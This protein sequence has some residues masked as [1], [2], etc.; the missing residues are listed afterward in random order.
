MVIVLQDLRSELRGRYL[1]VI[2]QLAGVQ[3]EVDMFSCTHVEGTFLSADIHGTEYLIENLKTP[4]DVYKSALLR[5]SDII[6]ITVS[7]LSKSHEP[8]PDRPL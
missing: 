3:C 8:E 5:H 1:S 6:S 4:A 7:D 2:R